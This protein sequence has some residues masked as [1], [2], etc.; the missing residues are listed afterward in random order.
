MRYSFFWGMLLRHWYLD[1]D[2]FTELSRFIYPISSFLLDISAV[3]NESTASY[4]RRKNTL[5]TQLRNF[6]TRNDSYLHIL[7]FLISTFHFISF[8]QV[9]IYVN[10]VSSTSCTR[11]IPGWERQNRTHESTINC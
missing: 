8:F 10:I 11:H 4:R 7:S 3:V 2:G 9:D 6:Q 5:S 1:P